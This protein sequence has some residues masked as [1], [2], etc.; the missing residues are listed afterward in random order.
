GGVV[1][2]A[3]LNTLPPSHVRSK[4][5]E[6]ITMINECDAEL[7]PKTILYRS[8]GL[9]LL[10]STPAS[11]PSDIQILNSVWKVVTKFKEPAVN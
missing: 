11:T 9:S 10:L 7:F 1:L 4:V 2:N 6:Y 3:L 5:Q 8:L